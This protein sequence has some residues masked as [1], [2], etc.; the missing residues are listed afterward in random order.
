MLA[1]VRKSVA[2]KIEVLLEVVGLLASLSGATLAAVFGRLTIALVLGA[3]VLGFFFRLTGRRR[4]AQHARPPE[5][6]WIY[7]AASV[8]ALVEVAAVVEATN[9]PVRFYQEGFVLLHWAIVLVGLGVAFWLQLWLFRVI[10]ARR[11]ARQVS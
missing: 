7:V 3:V 11:N 4:I 5:P 1:A 9:L 10:A 6:A 8:A 2:N